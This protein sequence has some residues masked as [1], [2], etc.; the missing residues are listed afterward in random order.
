MTIL[1][2]ILLTLLLVALFSLF[3]I[4]FSLIFYNT[5]FIPEGLQRHVGITNVLSFLF[6]YVIILKYFW[7]P[8]GNFKD[9]FDLSKYNLKLL[10]YLVLIVVGLHLLDRPFWDLGRIWQ[11]LNTSE[12]DADLN[13][14]HGYT[15]ALL[16]SSISILIVS[17]IFEEL[18]FRNFLLKQLI[19]RYS[20]KTSIIISSL[21]FAVIH[22]ETPFNI[23]P[24]FIFGLIS[25]LIYIK[26]KQ[27]GYSI[28]LHFLVNVLVQLF[29]VLD[30]NFDKWLMELNFSLT[31]WALFFVGILITYFGTKT[32]LKTE[33]TSLKDYLDEA[34]ELH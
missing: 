21:C 22:I 13:Q 15:P 12:F 29:Y 31:Y 20:L 14:F 1:R 32:I 10:P 4:G 19:E 25:S 11:Y 9:K 27:I 3:Q 16:Y 34:K 7:K 6:S 30:L 28:V 23:I 26:T 8:Q 24:T 2:A 5:D 33:E 18:F 17:P